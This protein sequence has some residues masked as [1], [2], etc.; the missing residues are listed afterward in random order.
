MKIGANISKNLFRYLR[1]NTVRAN[2][3]RTMDT[4]LLL[5][6]ST[7]AASASALSGNIFGQASSLALANCTLIGA[8]KALFHRIQ[9][10]PIRNRAIRIK[11]AAKEAAKQAK[12]INKNI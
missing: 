4:T 6:L 10:Q 7:C 3:N 11:K 2:Y 5:G 12:K 9:M 1:K 8:G